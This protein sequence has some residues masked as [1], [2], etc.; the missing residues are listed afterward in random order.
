MYAGGAV[1]AF[2]A[3]GIGLAAAPVAAGQPDAGAQGDGTATLP[4]VAAAPPVQM[5][6]PTSENANPVAVAAC[7]QF[8]DVLDATSTYYGDFAD[9]L[10]THAAPNYSDPYVE[11]SN[12][13][14][15]T[16]LRQGAGVAMSA[17]NTP[18]LPPDIAN[19]MRSWSLDATKL[20]VKMGLRTPGG[21]LDVTANEM[22]NDAT[23]VQQGCAAA[24]THA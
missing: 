14:G 3:V 22:N 15:R 20:L 24:G 1:A 13:L 5:S 8:A 16:A 19:P 7:S 12:V 23:A 10:E 17:A 6:A 21:T 2:V 4:P 18:G 9:A 11:D